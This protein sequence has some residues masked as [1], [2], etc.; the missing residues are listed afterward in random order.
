MQPI[1]TRHRH[2]THRRTM[3]VHR[4]WRLTPHMIRIELAGDVATLVSLGADDHIKLMVPVAGGAVEM[5][6]YT[7]LYHDAAAGRLTVDFAVHEAGPATR[8]AMEAKPGDTID[9]GGPRGSAVIAPVFDWYLLVGDETALPAIRRRLEELPAGVGAISLVA[10]IDAAEEQTF[11]T[12][13][14]H[15]ALWVH[16]PMSAAADPAPLLAALAGLDLP[17]GPGFVWI[18][19][20]AGIAGAL[21]RH[22]VEERGHPKEWLKAAGYWQQGVA[23]SHGPVTD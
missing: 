9:I 3:T 12:A 13:A 1:V 4:V 22:M 14:R 16:R 18:A 23:D 11:A 8:W 15:L 21:R 7:P 5:R 6:D 20:E 2:E 17:G 10:V 19:G